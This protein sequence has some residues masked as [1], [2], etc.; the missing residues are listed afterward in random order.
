M[1]PRGKIAKAPRIKSVRALTKEDL[2]KLGEKRRDI[3]RVQRFR[4]SHHR[5]ARLYA[6][7]YKTH[8]IMMMTGYSYQRLATLS[9]TPAFQDLIAGYRLEDVMEEERDEVEY[10][11][12]RAMLASLRHMNDHYDELDEVGELMPAKTALAIAA[13]CADRLGYSR[14]TKSTVDVNVYADRLDK[15]IRI[16]N[17]VDLIPPKDDF[18]RRI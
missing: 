5:V 16:A 13:D 6:R 12:R 11:Q 9:G 2:P 10:L 1:I 17:G 8:E 14:H 15:A 4:D 3:G 7:G 18:Q